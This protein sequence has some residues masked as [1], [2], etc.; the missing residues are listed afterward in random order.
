MKLLTDILFWI[1][2]LGILCYV[3]PVLII[4]QIKLWGKEKWQQL[5]NK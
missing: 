2:T 1:G 5:M 3:I 4:K